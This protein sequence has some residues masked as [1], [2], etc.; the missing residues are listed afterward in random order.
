MNT[1]QTALHDPKPDMIPKP[2]ARAMFALAIAS[3]G[4][5]AFA[6]VTGRPPV[7]QPQASVPVAERMIV[8]EGRD[9]QAVTLRNPDG[10]LIADL[11]HGGFITVIQNAMARERLVHRIDGNPP[12]RIVRYANGRL[13]AEDPAT[14]WSAELYAFGADNKA[15][16]ERLLDQ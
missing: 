11:P 1:H 7:G 5:V 6:A 4:L 15:A 16:F 3:L 8:L 13:V 12:L 14:G 2:L 10:S 9:A